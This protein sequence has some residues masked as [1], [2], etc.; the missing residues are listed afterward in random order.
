M[1]LAKNAPVAQLDRAPDYESGGQ[2]CESLRAR[3][4]VLIPSIA[5]S[6]ATARGVATRFR[7]PVCTSVEARSTHE[8]CA[9]WLVL[10]GGF[11]PQ[12]G[13]YRIRLGAIGTLEG[14]GHRWPKTMSVV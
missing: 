9:R 11:E 7:F 3:H 8:G 2:E 14:D 6:V 1:A 5:N 4:F 10:R 12:D 13:Q